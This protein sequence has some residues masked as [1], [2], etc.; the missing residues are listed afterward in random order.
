M[1]ASY[2]LVDILKVILNVSV[3]TDYIKIINV[4]LFKVV[5]EYLHRHTFTHGLLIYLEAPAV[6]N[7]LG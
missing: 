3:N 5:V 6:V 1:S 4:G 2:D 7:F